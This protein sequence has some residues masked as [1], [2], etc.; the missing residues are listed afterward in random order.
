M[1]KKGWNDKA[2]NTSPCQVAL[3]ALA[4][5]ADGMTESDREWINQEWSGR[6]D[7]GKDVTMEYEGMRGLGMGSW[8]HFSST[9]SHSQVLTHAP[10]PSLQPQDIPIWKWPMWV[11]GFGVYALGLIMALS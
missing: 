5:L 8:C 4:S 1:Q 6:V 3:A 9:V 10:P 2:R 7:A 11:A